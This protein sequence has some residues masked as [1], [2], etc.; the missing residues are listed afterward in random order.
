MYCVSRLVNMIGWD[1]CLV[2]K[3]ATECDWMRCHFGE[4][5]C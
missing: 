4:L 5:V 1:V 3:F 2:N